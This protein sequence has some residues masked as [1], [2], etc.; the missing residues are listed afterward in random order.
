[1]KEFGG[2]IEFEHNNGNEY[3]SDLINLNCGRNCLAYILKARAIR[4]IYLPYFLCNSV[5]DVCKKYNVKIEYY[6]IGQDFLPEFNKKVSDNEALYI[7]NFYGQIYDKEIKQYKEKYKIIIVDNAQAFFNKPIDDIDTIYTCRKYFGVPDGSY[8]KT[9]KKLEEELETDVSYQRMNFLLGRYEQGAEKFY[10]EYVDNNKLF[11]NEPIK[12]MSKLTHNLLRSIDYQFIIKR[13]TEN[14]E[15]LNS[16][17][18]KY[19]KLNLSVPKGAFMYP[20]YIE[21]G[22]E[23]KNELIKRKIFIPTLW[24]DV[25]D[26]TDKCAMEYDMAKNILPIPIDQRYNEEDMDYIMQEV[27]T[28]IN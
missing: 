13:R 21:N 17:F 14:F 9:D 18:K 6:N 7:V 5:D 24:P 27:I 10:S 19:N 3:Y 8:L 20:L 25:F 4:K 28:C 11:K 23:I 15:F 22:S 1:M 16:K 12:Y 26:K 2:Y